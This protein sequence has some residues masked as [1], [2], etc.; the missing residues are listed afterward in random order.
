MLFGC[1]FCSSLVGGCKKQSLFFSYKGKLSLGSMNL[2][3]RDG[4][5]QAERSRRQPS[6]HFVRLRRTVTPVPPQGW[7]GKLQAWQARGRGPKGELQKRVRPTKGFV[8]QP[9]LRVAW[10]FS[11]IPGK[12]GSIWR[13]KENCPKLDGV[14]PH[15]NLHIMRRIEGSLYTWEAHL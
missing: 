14:G 2:H 15:F 11:R 8:L 4:V 1:W 7:K 12:F 9:T 13:G 10:H 6:L 3:W 5:F